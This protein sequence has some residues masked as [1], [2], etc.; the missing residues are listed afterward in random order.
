VADPARRAT[1]DAGD[2]H[3]FAPFSPARPARDECIAEL[4]FRRGEFE[5]ARAEF[6]EAARRAAFRISVLEA[7]ARQL[8]N[9][10]PTETQEEAERQS[11][12]ANRAADAERI[13]DQTARHADL[14]AAGRSRTAADVASA[15]CIFCGLFVPRAALEEHALTAH[16]A[17]ARANFYRQTRGER[18]RIESLERAAFARLALHGSL[19]A[20]RAGKEAEERLSRD[21][22]AK[23]LAQATAAKRAATAATP[24][25]KAAA[26]ATGQSPSSAASAGTAAPHETQERVAAPP[27][28]TETSADDIFPAEERRKRTRGREE[29]PTEKL[30]QCRAQLSGELAA[31]SSYVFAGPP[32]DTTETAEHVWQEPPADEATAPQLSPQGFGEEFAIANGRGRCAMNAAA[33]ALHAAVGV[34]GLHAA[35]SADEAREFCE[36]WL[37]PLA[38]FTPGGP[39]N[40]ALALTARLFEGARV[41][42]EIRFCSGAAGGQPSARFCLQELPLG[43]GGVPQ[44]PAADHAITAVFFHIPGV[45]FVTA[46]FVPRLSLWAAAD[47]ALLHLYSSFPSAAAPWQVAGVLW[48][49]GPAD[50]FAQVSLGNGLLM[51]SFAAA[52]PPDRL[53]HSRPAR[54]RTMLCGACGAQK[55]VGEACPECA[56]AGAES[57][58]AA[59]E[60]A[61][62]R[63]PAAPGPDSGDDGPE[64]AERTGQRA[65]PRSNARVEQSPRATQEE[66]HRRI[67]VEARR[68]HSFLLA[69]LLAEAAGKRV[70]SAVRDILVHALGPQLWAE[71]V[72]AIRPLVSDT[73]FVSRGGWDY[74]AAAAQEAVLDALFL[75]DASLG[76]RFAQAVADMPPPTARRAEN[77]LFRGEQVAC[78]GGCAVGRLPAGAAHRNGRHRADCAISRAN[79]ANAAFRRTAGRSAYGGAARADGRVRAAPCENFWADFPARDPQEEPQPP[80]AADADNQQQNEAEEAAYS[81]QHNE[82]EEAAGG[83][84]E[85]AL[86]EIMAGKKRVMQKP[87][88]STVGRVAAVL[89]Q[90][91][92]DAAAAPQGA[93]QWTRLLLFAPLVLCLPPPGVKKEKWVI[94][95]LALWRRRRFQELAASVP[96]AAPRQN[97]GRDGAPTEDCGHEASATIRW[98]TAV[99][100]DDL[101]P[102][103]LRQAI[104][105]TKAGRYSRAVGRLSAAAVAPETPETFAV[106]LAKNAPERAEIHDE[107]GEP[108][109]DDAPELTTSLVRKCLFSFPAGSAGG[110]SGLGVELLKMCVVAGGVGFLEALRAVVARIAR[111]EVPAPVRPF[112]FGARLIALLKAP[113]EDDTPAPQQDEQ[114]QQTKPPDLRP[115][116]CGEVLRRLGAKALGKKAR[117]DVE[118]WLFAC[119][120]VGAFT[121]GGLDA[122][123]LSARLFSTKAL[124]DP[125]LVA[126]CI[127]IENAFNSGNRRLMLAAV[128]LHCPKLWGYARAALLH[129]YLFFS[130]KVIASTAGAQQGDPLGPLLFAVLFCS[131]LLRCPL[132]LAL[133]LRISFLDDG[134]LGGPRPIVADA[135]AQ[136][137][138]IFAEAGL[139]INVRKSRLILDD[140]SSARRDCDC[141]S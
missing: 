67:L 50:G 64:G 55:P 9:R 139:K 34:Q 88:R 35:K 20:G 5:Q 19:L 112:V 39:V 13:A 98:D 2:V 46:A 17:D 106:M 24:A 94:D 43:S 135:F 108:L 27:A 85:P 63:D 54:S 45:H 126:L 41:P 99:G 124:V 26:N 101:S 53:T 30:Q 73:V 96:A 28:A 60:A 52:A 15:M 61:E 7:F 37:D 121:A 49:K 44:P 6:E 122:A 36:K 14:D 16:F 70:K 102:A 92:A 51:S 95:R 65:R 1:T 116:A 118:P 33:L 91:L 72:A 74:P 136:L 141:L 113:R 18:D 107:T 105:E 125:E 58:A 42:L 133:P 110:P 103:T 76:I 109:G 137:E 77:E 82:A 130:G 83:E 48:T 8:A 12:L 66:A 132:A 29:L 138:P 68:P 134:L 40:N 89:R 90:V 93:L 38:A 69:P 114:Q 115:I 75:A 97:E 117:D 31:S 140:G 59:P 84:E 4:V 104:A 79:A 22:L 10:G 111:G 62:E 47:D 81:Q 78:S 119:G 71:T 100:A 25:A 131:L 3:R 57:A 123:V 127:D 129:S 128:R 87:P 120:Q 11:I 23:R 56:R 21:R 80:P 86:L 32:A